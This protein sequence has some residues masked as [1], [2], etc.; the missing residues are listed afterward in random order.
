MRLYL[1]KGANNEFVR[2]I[3]QRLIALGFNCG[4]TGSDSYFGTLTLVA[5]Q[6]FQASRGLKADGVVGQLTT[7]HLLK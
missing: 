5:V 4:K 3:Q 1:T 6:N 7:T 2:W